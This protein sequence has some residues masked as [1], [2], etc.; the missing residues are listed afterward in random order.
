M[1]PIRKILA[2]IS[3]R[4]C[5]TLAFHLH[6]PRTYS[7]LQAGSALALGAGLLLSL[8]LLSGVF[9]SAQER[10]SDFLYQPIKPSGQVVLVTVDDASLREIG[11]LPWP[12]I[13]Y[14]D[15]LSAIA[16]AQPRTV[17]FDLVLAEPADG[18][19]ALA[20]ALQS[21]P[22]IV[23]PIVSV[24]AT[25]F[26]P[27][28][29]S[30][31]RF[32][33]ALYPSYSLRT[34]NTLLA[35]TTVL[36]DADGIVR[37]VPIAI[38][39]SGKPYPALALAALD[40]AMPERLEVDAVT[41]GNRRLPVDSQGQIYINFVNSSTSQV[42][43]FADIASGRADLTRLHDRI[44]LIGS[45]SSSSPV[46]YETPL[47]IGGERAYPVQIQAD[48]IETLVQ[49]RLLVLQDRLVEL[50]M[51][52]LV[53]LLAGATLVHVRLLTSAALT[54]LYFVFYLGYAF[55]EFREGTIVQPLYPTL[56][57]LLT[58]VSIRVYRYL[59]R[60]RERGLTEHL[61]RRHAAPE[62]VAEVLRQF[63]HDKLTLAGAQREITVLYIDMREFGQPVQSLR[64]DQAVALLN[65]YLST[66]VTCIFHNGGLVMRQ[67][68]SAIVATWNI[69]I[70]QADHARRATRAA[71]EI[72]DEVMRLN[73]G[74]PRE[75]AAGVGMGIAT[76][77]VTAG[78]VG[79]GRLTEFAI[80]GQ[81]LTIAEQLSMRRDGT[82]FIDG[83]TR[84]KIA[85]SE[86]DT[87][88]VN[89]L[90]LRR[91]SDPLDVWEITL[92]ASPEPLP[93]EEEKELELID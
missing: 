24:D 65:R 69:P 75:L 48:L 80:L 26:P 74:Q 1:D 82:I 90:R 44:V 63:D 81:V 33:A 60:D 4:V 53:A 83:P 10:L 78:R 91:K 6:S 22:R 21:F 88:P 58:F 19:G 77:I 38:L 7:R 37:R 13:V 47:T 14:A 62:T 23:Q 54:I 70:D 45:T 46:L 71:V 92:P 66:A 61:F 27:R 30:F 17:I 73:D 67:M 25:R 49:N 35:H 43:S 16:Q 57:L 2:S 55:Q 76:G 18:D 29:N 79:S 20:Q 42:I 72:R 8:A 32:E 28:P 87:R 11:P 12:R 56:A 84:S 52:F 31:P 40:F 51:I 86:F 68:G 34:P 3:G 5:E 50:T 9:H 15:A 39:V 64:A 36:P 93:D 89:R 85:D 41:I 59:E